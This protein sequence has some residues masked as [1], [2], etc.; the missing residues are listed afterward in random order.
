MINEA[1][2]DD[3]ESNSALASVVEPSEAINWP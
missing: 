1:H 2:V 3:A